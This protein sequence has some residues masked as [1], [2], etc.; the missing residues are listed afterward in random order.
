MDWL[1][2]LMGYTRNVAYK[3]TSI[4]NVDLKEVHTVKIICSFQEKNGF[5]YNLYSF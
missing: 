1:L 2:E 4:Q 3:S 5:W